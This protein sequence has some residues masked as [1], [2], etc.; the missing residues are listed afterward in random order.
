MTVRDFMEQTDI[1]QVTI[2]LQT[3][4]FDGAKWQG[5]PKEKKW[6]IFA[7]RKILE[8][9]IDEDKAYLIIEHKENA[10]YQKISKKDKKN[11]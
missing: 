6:H 4:V 2:F 3:K 9:K 5:S 8:K 10:H 7:A 1:K 11:W